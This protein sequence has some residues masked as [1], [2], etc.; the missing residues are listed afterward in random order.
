MPSSL[1]PLFSPSSIAVIGAS[2]RPGT[3]GYEIVDNLL[4]HR[5]EGV[6]YAVNPR[7]RSVHSLPTW[8]SVRDIPGE[9]D[10]AVVVVPKEAV[11]EVIDQCGARGIPA[12]VVI[13]AGFS[14]VGEEGHRREARLQARARR[15]GM[16]VVGPNSM[17]ILNTDPAVRMN[18]T[19][20]PTMPP[21]GS[22]S[23]LSQSGAVGMTILDY[24]A[25]YGI[26]IRHFVSVGNKADVSGNDLLEHWEDDPDT[27]VILMYLETFGNPRHFT[28]IA[29]RISRKKPLIVVKPG[30]TGREA[31]TGSWHTGELA[32]GDAA[33][34]ALL[35]QC[36][37]LRAHTV[38]ELF[39]LAMA[40]GTLPPPAGGRVA[41]VTNAGGPGVMIADA[42]R[43]G[44]LELVDLPEPT[45]GALRRDLAA[46]EAS[47]GNP[48]D[49]IATAE[50]GSYGSALRTVL[51]APVVDGVIAAFM[52][53][54]GVRQ[55]DVAGVI[56]EASREHPTK[57]LLAVFMGRDGLR[58]GRAALHE[59]GVPAYIFPESAARALAALHGYGRWLRQPVQA[60]THFQVEKAVVSGILDAA[61]EQGETALGTEE[62]RAILAAYGIPSGPG[63]VVPSRAAATAAA[64]ELGFPVVLKAPPPHIVERF[65]VGGSRGELLDAAAVGAAYDAMAAEMGDRGLDDASPAVRVAPFH[66]HAQ[67]LILGMTTDATFGPLVMFGLGG[68]HVETLRDVTFRV[69]PVTEQEAHAM[70]SSIRSF[71]LLRGVNGGPGVD[72]VS[73][74]GV[75]QRLS[76][77]VIDH[78]RIRELEVDPLVAT[79]EGATAQEVRIRVVP[80]EHL[81]TAS[82]SYVG[83][84]R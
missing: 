16:R 2:R 47:V 83:P 51:R 40:F 3:V 49:L 54:F 52:P 30:R 28:R 39:D 18:A 4:K 13:S 14:E 34:D 62:G 5:Y 19:F 68:P 27:R 32:S 77:L 84:A 58:K 15:Y 66:R 64:A 56:V 6:V 1:H 76:Q 35:E 65:D 82:A 63:R 31:G 60:P 33:V 81:G 53:P 80:R 59:A 12:A 20:A 37:V 26:G 61:T 7:A 44:G 25:E 41:V 11:L 9:V 43:K 79:P 17:G 21:A 36:G 73:L 48:V 38:E 22:V 57:P 8:R 78:P 24:A 75:I 45:I 23:L 69:P 71:P 74:A 29:R 10:L 67:E 72:L 46:E 55:E 70:I 50:P 42:C